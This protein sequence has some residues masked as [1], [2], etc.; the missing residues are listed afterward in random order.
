MPVYARAIVAAALCFLLVFGGYLALTSNQL[1]VQMIEV[2]LIEDSDPSFLFSKIK[3][4]LEPR[5]AGF[6]GSFIWNVDLDQA[7]DMVSRDRRIKEAQVA[8]RWPNRLEV[9]I[10]PH[11]ALGNILPDRS[12]LVY[13]LSYDGG[14]LPPVENSQAADAP[15]LRG[16]VFLKNEAVRDLVLALLRAL[17]DEGFVSSKSVSEVLYSDKDGLILLLNLDGSRV[18]LGREDFS[19]R[20]LYVEQVVRYLQNEN[21]RGRVIDARFQ[22]KVVVRPRNDT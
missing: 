15:L 8:R 5:F 17:P 13:P 4:D 2:N 20:L 7:L 22:K 21:I 9:S 1:K 18:V 16:K 12:N 10:Q 19:K 11:R 14:I 6:L 3:S